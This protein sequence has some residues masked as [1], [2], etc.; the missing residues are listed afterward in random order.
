M[1]SRFR[2][3]PIMEVNFRLA[4]L[5]VGQQIMYMQQI[6]PGARMRSYGN[7]VVW[8][9][10]LRP[11]SF[12]DSYLVEIDYR[13]RQTP[14]VRVLSPD[15]GVSRERYHEVHIF[16]DGS[17]CLHSSSN[18]DASTP[19]ATTILLW[20]N[21]WLIYYE[22]WKT[23]GRWYGGGEYTLTTRDRKRIKRRNLETARAGHSGR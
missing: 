21:E 13:Q 3:T 2:I 20:A 17:L 22:L 14:V 7:R 12:S 11:T 1:P 9:V 4:A 23:T 8:L 6:C 5:S 16:R 18:W 19:I 10:L 15:L